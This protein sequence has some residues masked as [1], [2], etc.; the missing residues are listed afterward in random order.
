MKK[1]LLMIAFFVFTSVVS[2]QTINRDY[3]DG[4]IYFQLK[5]DA[6]VAKTVGENP[7]NLNPASIPFLKS[8]IRSCGVEKLSRPFFTAKGSEV[9]QRTYLLEFSNYVIADELVRTIENNPT[10][11]YAEKAPIRTCDVIPNDPSYSSQWPLTLINASNAWNYSTGSASITVAIVDNAIETAHPDLAANMWTNPNEIASNGID[12]DNNGYIDDVQGYDVA[13]LDNNPNPPTVTTGYE[14]GTQ[15]TG[16]AAAVSNNNVGI[17]SIGYGIKIIPVKC[18]NN[19]SYLTNSL[20]GILYAAVMKANVI[21][22]SFSGATFNNTEN[23]VIQYAYNRGCVLVSGAGNDGLNKKKYPAGYLNVIAVAAT[24]SSDTKASFSNWGTHIDI[25]APGENIYTTN[26]GGGYTTVSGTSFS[27]PMIAGMCGLMLSLN[28]NL[29]QQDVETCIKTN[30]TNITSLNSAYPGIVGRVEANNTMACVNASLAW[31][32]TAN[33]YS[34]F[35]GIFAGGNIAFTDSSIHGATT[36]SWTFPG[37]NPSSSNLRTPPT[38]V[39][40]TAGKYDVTLTVSNANGSDTRTKTQYIDVAAEPPCFPLNLGYVLNTTWTPD[41]YEVGIGLFTGFV[42]GKNDMDGGTEVAQYFDASWAPFTALQYATVNIYYASCAD[43]TKVITFNVYD[44]TTGKP[45]ALLGSK[46]MTMNELHPAQLNPSHLVYIN[47][48]TIL[49][50]TSKKFFIGVNYSSLTW[51]STVKDSLA[52]MNNSDGQTS[53]SNVWM[54]SNSK[55]TKFG[56]NG[57]PWSFQISMLMFPYLSTTYGIAAFTASA[58]TICAGTAITFDASPSTS[59]DTMR[60]EFKGAADS[61]WC[62]TLKPTITYNNPGT[63]RAVLRTRNGGCSKLDTTDKIITVLPAAGC[64]AGIQNVLSDENVDVFYNSFDNK[65]HY[66]LINNPDIR[67]LSVK[68]IDMFGRVVH[69]ESA[70]ITNAAKSFTID[71]SRYATGI[72]VF[73]MNSSDH[74]YCKKILVD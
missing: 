34:N 6:V 26:V 29:T 16:C 65:I 38:I 48:P 56:T 12:D 37:G 62:P 20:D 40:P 68:L 22:M 24:T 27:T 13:D 17:A 67:Q 66:S 11:V 52:I 60:F 53:P 46:N 64:T 36:W 2:A 9:L 72:Y 15:T 61:C 30:A 5:S 59:L 42:L 70:E 71:M 31:K 10:V 44:G 23:N 73:Q 54:Y 63:F 1:V 74:A 32:P 51:S 55:W 41:F 7:L 8:L 45:G 49:L 25:C 14:H 57:S 58:T 18:T 50:P 19:T 4:K 3:I 69:V 43:L 28:P 33:F 35:I 21:S 47:F 39:Y